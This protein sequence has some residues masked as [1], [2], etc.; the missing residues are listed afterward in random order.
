[1]SI[2]IS[3]RLMITLLVVG[4]FP[5]ILITSIFFFQTSHMM[6]SAVKDK[7][8]S[9]LESKS[10]YINYYFDRKKNDAAFLASL[11]IIKDDGA[12]LINIGIETPLNTDRFNKHDSAIRSY[13]TEYMHT[14]YFHDFLIISLSG[15]IVF[16]IE[17]EDDYNTNLI[18]GPYKDTELGTSFR[19]SSS[20]LS[21]NTTKIHYYEPSEI[22][23]VFIT[24]PIFNDGEI[25]GVLAAQV[26]LSEIYNIIGDYRGLGR[27]GEVVIGSQNG[28]NIDIVN[29]L[30]HDKNAAFNR[31]ILPGSSNGIA[32]QSA[33][34][35]KNG[36]DTY[37]DY[38]NNSVVGAWKYLPHLQAGI[39][40]KQN[41]SELYEKIYLLQKV[42]IFIIIVTIV[43]ILLI[44][45][46]V[47]N[48][49]TTP[50]KTLKNATHKMA[51]NDLTG[52]VEI[53]RND[54]IGEL[55]K[56]FNSMSESLDISNRK[57]EKQ[58]KNIKDIN[59]K[60]NDYSFTISHDLKEPVRSV[61][62]FSQ[63][64]LEDYSDLFDDDGK[65]Y[66]TRIIRASKRMG[67][68]I[69]DLL[70]LSKVGRIDIFFT[71]ENLGDLLSDLVDGL[72][73]LLDATKSTITFE[74]MPTVVCQKSWITS[75][76]QNLITNAIK[77]SD[78]ENTII[79]INCDDKQSYYE[80]TV[81]DNGI[82]IEE[83][84]FRKIFG[85]FRRATKDKL[86]EGS[87]AG[88][89]IVETVIEEHKGKI[90]VDESTLGEGTIIKFTIN[91][92]L[93]NDKQ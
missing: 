87:G 79:L 46:I 3:K 25:V 10:R 84:Q 33:I 50:I 24:L 12:E 40:V 54:E 74:N 66:L 89:A 49:I 11:P 19:L 5:V 17:H 62:T 53:T 27:T 78:K 15:D 1:M 52:R 81:S 9:T 26:N 35:G 71:R 36:V 77:Y 44:S 16:S 90:W 73:S 92:E 45:V 85:L 56:A 32:L 58:L 51:L 48:E 57:I 7:M 55:G 88:L 75:V 6:K 59:K 42:S 20:L 82:G 93:K 41:Q 14:N 67:N 91:K 70:T 21:K 76:F 18:T 80:F 13:L 63:F 72:S 86:S 68:M 23:A 47:S 8:V 43:M 38:L 39:V 61:H 28:N 69:D 34:N 29:P 83:N 22:P 60:L 4:I 37:T 2:S 30:R 64:I 65:D 31:K